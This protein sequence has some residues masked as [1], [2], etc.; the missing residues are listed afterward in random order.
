MG[1]QGIV[2]KEWPVLYAGDVPWFDAVRWDFKISG[3]V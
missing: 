1:W 2:L 3:L